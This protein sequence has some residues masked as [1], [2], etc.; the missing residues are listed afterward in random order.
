[1]Y[2]LP[3]TVLM[4]VYNAEPYLKEAIESILHQTYSDFEFL[5]IND[6]STD[7][8]K[9]IIL[10]Y[11]DSRIRYIENESN[12][13]LIATLNKGIGLAKGKYIVRMDADDISL[14]ERLKLLYGFMESHP[15]VGLCGSWFENFSKK[16][17]TGSVKYTTDD[18][19]IRLKQLHQIHLSHGTCIFRTDALKKHQLCFNPEYIHAEDYEKASAIRDEINRRKKE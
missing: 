7:S 15:N 13:K 12:M 17:N 6:G 11:H 19:T 10:S 16:G 8:S 18:S 5:I 2:E 1:M 9:D 4:P 14:P 3:V